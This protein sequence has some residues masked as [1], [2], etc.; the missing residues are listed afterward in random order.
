MI[1]RQP[2][3]TGTHRGVKDALI[4]MR[5]YSISWITQMLARRSFKFVPSKHLP[6]DDNSAS[7]ISILCLILNFLSGQDG[8]HRDRESARLIA[9]S[10]G[11]LT[12]EL[13]RRMSD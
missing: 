3:T 8:K 4:S 2:V 10:G 1:G 7:T 12:D 5:P 13:E 6:G 11:R 9:R